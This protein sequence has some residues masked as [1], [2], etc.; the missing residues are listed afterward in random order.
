MNEPSIPRS[1]VPK[2]IEAIK[3]IAESR[4]YP[5]RSIHV[6]CDVKPTWDNPEGE[7]VPRVVADIRFAEHI[8]GYGT[9]TK[10]TVTLCRAVSNFAPV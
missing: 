9:V 10:E 6:E 8:E 7:P 1:H 3:T 4:P 2:L 5:V